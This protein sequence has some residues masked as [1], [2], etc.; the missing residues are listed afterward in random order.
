LRGN[1]HHEGL[2]ESQARTKAQQLLDGSAQPA[3]SSPLELDLAMLVKQLVR[4][5]RLSHP[6]SALATRA[7][8]FLQRQGLFGSPLREQLATA[9]MCEN[10]R[11]SKLVDDFMEDVDLFGPLPCRHKL[12]VLL[13]WRSVLFPN[14]G[15][16]EKW[17]PQKR[18][19]P[20]QPRKR[21]PTNQ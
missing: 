12:H 14:R 11:P 16:T 21:P 3:R 2:D 4:V 5:V 10:H 18:Q 7:M 17:Q 13:E 6:D 15:V 1:Q 9:E 8:D 20:R 19:P